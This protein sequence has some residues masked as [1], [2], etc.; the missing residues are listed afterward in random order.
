MELGTLTNQNNTPN[1]EIPTQQS[2]L[3]VCCF[4]YCLVY[5]VYK[6]S[7]MEIHMTSL[8]F[9]TSIKVLQFTFIAACVQVYVTMGPGGE[10][11]GA[12]VN[13]FAEVLSQVDWSALGTR[14]FELVTQLMTEVMGAV[15]ESGIEPETVA[16]EVIDKGLE[17]TNE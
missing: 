10:S 15:A 3:H 11:V 17:N 12:I 1:Q 9:Y 14:L 2:D 16:S 8:F 4:V 6:T 5:T 13:S 7:L